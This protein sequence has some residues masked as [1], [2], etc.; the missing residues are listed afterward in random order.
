M[1]R[2]TVNESNGLSIEQFEIAPTVYLDHWAIRLLSDDKPLQDNFISLMKAQKATLMLSWLN[3]VEFSQVEDTKAHKRAE[4]FVELL[5]PNIFFMEVNPFMVISRENELLNGGQPLPPHA[6]KG[7]VKEFSFLKCSSLMGFTATGL[8]SPMHGS[9]VQ[10]EFG[11]LEDEIVHRLELQR[12]ELTENIS[13]QRI[14]RRPPSGPAIQ[15]GT[16]YVFRELARSFLVNKTLKLSRNHAID[17]MHSVVPTSYC[18]YVLL[19]A[20]WEVQVAR[21]QERFSK[22]KMQVPLARVY[23]KKEHGLERFLEALARHKN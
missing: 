8:F 5:L 17:L 22:A 7:F 21:I 23:S 12:R 1:I 11:T 13:F 20:H 6:D 19:D 2:Y 3:L 16:R 10:S 15:L 9:S 4:E 18:D 14:I